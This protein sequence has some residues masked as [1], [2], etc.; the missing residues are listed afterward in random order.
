MKRAYFIALMFFCSLGYFEAPA[1][2]DIQIR[3]WGQAH[4]IE[5]AVIYGVFR[6]QNDLIWIFT[7]NGLYYF[8]GFRAYKSP[9][10]EAD[11][12]TSFDGIVGQLFQSLDGRYWLLVE[13][14]LGSYDIYSKVFKPLKANFLNLL[15]RFSSAGDQ[16]FVFDPSRTYLVDK[17]SL[18]LIPMVFVDDQDAI[19]S[20][21]IRPSGFPTRYFSFL[22]ESPVEVVPS[23]YIGKY[24]QKIDVDSSQTFWNQQGYFPISIDV[25]GNTWYRHPLNYQDL[26][27][28]DSWG[29]NVSDKILSHFEGMTIHFFF[30]Q[31]DYSW[32]VTDSGLV[33]WEKNAVKPV[34]RFE[35]FP[36]VSEVQLAQ[37]FDRGKTIWFWNRQGLLNLR[38]NPSKFSSITKENLG[39]YSNFILGIFPFDENRLIIKHDFADSYYSFFDLQ[40]GVVSPVHREEIFKNFGLMEYFEIRR[41]G[42][43]KFW[44][45]NNGKHL[46][47]FFH[48]NA[49]RTLFTHSFISNGNSYEYYVYPADEFDLGNQL[50]RISDNRM[51]FPRIS[52]L[53]YVQQGDTVWIGTESEGLV[54]LH[55]PSGQTQQW[56]SD[57]GRSES[58][59]ANR[60]HAV[61]PVAYGN[62]WLG[63]GNGLS[64][65][66]KKSGKFKTY[67]KQE[68]LINNRIYCMAF[69]KNG[70]LWI[71]TG[72]G[73]SRFDTLSKS[74]TN[75]TKAEGLVNREYNRNSAILLPDGR[76]MM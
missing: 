62:L 49:N 41:H 53:Q 7:Y 26:I 5:S 8:D 34:N 37:S 25:N 19:I 61:I 2:S 30:T 23:K 64:F 40:T 52:P 27:V 22:E 67:R 11:G 18:E 24:F 74:F 4:G 75:F 46:H 33:L 72:N 54:A 69:D 42:D 44:I 65:F 68:G 43:P 28:E 48:S 12:K 66:N 15:S 13:D 55:T 70:L 10:L 38:T 9:I 36:E 6:D 56:L 31:P 51:V 73:L 20:D 1:Q 60:V 16:L 17:N 47:N 76:M 35:N 45:L 29:R 21:D 57:S 32:F 58:I 39:L 50:W 3:S 71:G 63:T 14:K 59:P